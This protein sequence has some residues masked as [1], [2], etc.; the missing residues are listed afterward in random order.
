L[1]A[2]IRGDGMVK[3][4]GTIIY[5]IESGLDNQACSMATRPRPK[6]EYPSWI[7]RLPLAHR[8]R[9]AVDIPRDENL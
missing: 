5:G 3:K 1:L 8:K 2:F 4:S 6:S 9:Y 7:K